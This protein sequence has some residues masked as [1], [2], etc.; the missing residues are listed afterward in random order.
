[1]EFGQSKT[2]IV[3]RNA[4]LADMVKNGYSGE[5]KAKRRCA[6]MINGFNGMS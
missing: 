5:T 1:M 4:F 3:R 6:S 2:K